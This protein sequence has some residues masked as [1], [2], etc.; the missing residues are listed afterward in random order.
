[1]SRSKARYLAF[2]AIASALCSSSCSLVSLESLVISTEPST[3]GEILSPEGPIK[4]SF[5]IEPVHAN[6]ER[7]FKL[8][9]AAGSSW[10][11]FR[12]SASE[13]SFYPVPP[14]RR[15]YRWTLAI[16]GNLKALD[17]RSFDVD[18]VVSF[19][20]GSS[21][22]LLT[23][24]SIKPDVGA[25][26]STTEEIILGFSRKVN[27]TIFTRNFS[28]SPSTDYEAVWSTDGKTVTLAPKIRWTSLSTY[29]WQIKADLADD[30]GVGMA[31][32]YDGSFVVQ[33]DST[34]PSL[35]SAR[36]AL[37]VDGTLSPLAVDLDQ[38]GYRDAIYLSFSE[39]MTLESVS[40]AVKLTPSVKGRVLQDGEDD[41]AFVPEEGFAARTKYKLS[42]LAS[43]VDLAGNPMPE[44]YV[45]WFSPSV[46]DIN[47]LRAYIN[48]GAAVT[49]FGDAYCYGLSPSVSDGSAAIA[50][51]FNIPIGDAAERNRIV[52]LISCA[53]LFPSSL[54]P[55]L[56][57]VQ[58]ASP[59]R[60]ELS[61]AGFSAST[62]SK[63]YYYKLVVPGGI[64]G[65]SDGA[66]GTM[67][68]D[69]WLVM[70]TN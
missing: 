9:S 1:M 50:L 63:T 70:F 69:A 59:S 67:E 57:S 32:D 26:A 38:L 61:Y 21:S 15:G 56:K 46:A 20:A 22:S 33:A 58:W 68:K 62:A 44:D 24:D 11:D 18:K 2:L 36:P 39:G 28:L 52:S 14:L 45:T 6:A 17:G 53:S 4:V 12:W 31:R 3:D 41:F 43:A 8:S 66:G 13:L 7:A 10:G 5:S 42:I 65:I 60:L 40:S 23:L 54:S 55:A 19:Y 64:S 48:G 25:T 16:A 29:A 27:Q 37:F 30:E 51:Y 49:G 47:I 35:V 34:A